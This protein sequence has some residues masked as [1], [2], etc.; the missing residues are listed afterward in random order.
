MNDLLYIS[1][2][3]IKHLTRGRFFD[4]GNMRFFKSRLPQDGYTTKDCN[5]I[6]FITSEKFEDNPRKYTIRALDKKT[7][8]I[9]TV[10][11]FQS[12]M[13]RAPAKYAV[14]NLL[15]IQRLRR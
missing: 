7:G 6:Y 4:Q 12:Y 13:H 1:I 8:M 14:M 10:A 11:N 15:N 5:Y 2:S 3:E 9:N